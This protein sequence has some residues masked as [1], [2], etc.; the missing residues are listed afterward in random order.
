MKP[1]AQTCSTTSSDQ[2]PRIR[3]LS[4]TTRTNKGSDNFSTCR[5]GFP[6][7]ESYT[8]NTRCI[9]N[10]LAC[11]SAKLENF[12]RRSPS[13][14]PTRADW[15]F[16]IGSMHWCTPSHTIHTPKLL[17]MSWWCL[18]IHVSDTKACHVISYASPNPSQRHII[19]WHQRLY[20]PIRDPT[21]TPG[22]NPDCVDHWLTQT[23]DFWL[24]ID[25]DPFEF[26][27]FIDF[28]PKVKISKIT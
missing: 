26:D 1:T 16:G 3:P 15:I 20:S 8:G 6:R 18:S 9:D 14:M 22:T 25:F 2:N 13:N 21:Q 17:M 5:R 11:R 23:V 24:A 12:G 27:F 28:W 19:R 4:A 7:C 10:L